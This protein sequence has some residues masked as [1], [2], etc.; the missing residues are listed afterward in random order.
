MFKAKETTS[1]DIQVP[2]CARD[3]T[4]FHDGLNTRMILDRREDED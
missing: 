1:C 3:Y 2:D 4:T